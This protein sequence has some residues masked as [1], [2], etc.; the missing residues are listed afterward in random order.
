MTD[1][2]VVLMPLVQTRSLMPT[3]TPASGPTFFPAMISASTAFACARATSGDGV[4]KAPSTG[5]SLSIR[6]STASVTSVAERY[7][8]HAADFV[9][10]RGG[11]SRCSRCC[12]RVA[13]HGGSPC[14]DHELAPRYP[15]FPAG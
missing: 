13:D 11:Q 12:K 1:P 14:R 7:C 5:L 10:R 8:V 4:Q 15:V 6:A 3:G 9:C 2:D